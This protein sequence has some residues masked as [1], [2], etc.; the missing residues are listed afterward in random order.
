VR[1]DGRS[2]SSEQV[3]LVIAEGRRRRLRLGFVVGKKIGGA[4]LRNRCRRRLRE[5]V[6]VQMP[7]ITEG[8]DLV[9][10][11]RSAALADIP[12]D[13]LCRTVEE[14]LRRGRL[15][16]APMP[17]TAAPAAMPAEIGE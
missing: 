16:R 3:S 17:A 4:V 10:H 8:F 2:F 15:W 11:V 6:R 1:R 5:A 13:A 12:F 9:F 7:Q 14:L